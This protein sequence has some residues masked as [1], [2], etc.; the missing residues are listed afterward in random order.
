MP[1][2]ATSSSPNTTGAVNAGQ[3]SHSETS[4]GLAVEWPTWLVIAAIALAWGVL[5]FGVPQLALWL[6]LGALVLVLTWYMSL[7]HELIHGHPTRNAAVNRSLGLLPLAVWYPYDL[8]RASHLTHHHDPDLTLPG[9]DPESNYVPRAQAAHMSAVAHFLA[10]SQRTVLGRLALGPG[11][12]IAQLARE[13]TRALRQPRSAHA[14]TLLKAW[15]VHGALLAALLW[16]LASYAQMAVWQYIALAA[17]PALG[18][19][20]LRSLYEHRPAALPAHRIVVN[21]AGLLWR[22]LYLNNNY[23]AVHHAHPG[24]AWYRI[25]ANYWADRAG[26]LE[27]NGGFRVAGYAWLF[28]HYAWRPIDAC[29]HGSLPQAQHSATRKSSF[30]SHSA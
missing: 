26:Y 4:I 28:R 30:F 23:H 25:P 9:V 20:M 11:L 27:R 19:A 10:A 7:Q 1:T 21:E 16:V 2:P 5:V 29:V 22:L 6:R 3:H 17:Y 13:L 14:H 18:L 15:A 24:L 8:Y 12:V